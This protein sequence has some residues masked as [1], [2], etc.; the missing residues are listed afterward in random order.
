MSRRSVWKPQA[1]FIK[2]F[3][4]A[5]STLTIPGYHHRNASNAPETDTNLSS[6]QWFGQSQIVAKCTSCIFVLSENHAMHQPF[7]L[8]TLN[9]AETSS[10]SSTC[11]TCSCSSSTTGASTPGVLDC[12]SAF[13][14]A[15]G[16]TFL[17][18]SK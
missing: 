16:C 1:L 2:E 17:H 9:F 10:D 4:G 8:E 7:L 18:L 11:S 6:S 14:S 3:R 12:A 15:G 13:A 5:E